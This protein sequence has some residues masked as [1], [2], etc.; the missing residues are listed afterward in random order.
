MRF[1]VGFTVGA[2]LTSGLLIVVLVGGLLLLADR[3]D[4]RLNQHPSASE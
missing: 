2:L 4:Q 1:I 3:S